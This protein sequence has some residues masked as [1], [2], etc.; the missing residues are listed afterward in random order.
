MKGV[1][2]PL[3]ASYIWSNYFISAWHATIPLHHGIPPINPFQG[4]IGPWHHG[5]ASRDETLISPK[6]KVKKS[7]LGFV[8]YLNESSEAD[9]QPS[10]YNQTFSTICQGLPIFVEFYVFENFEFQDFRFS[11]FTVQILA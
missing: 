10:L 1:G 6:L 7:I 4:L 2:H 8:F 9:I 3:P 5:L 11:I